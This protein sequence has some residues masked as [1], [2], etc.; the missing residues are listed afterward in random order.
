MLLQILLLSA[1]AM[2]PRTIP[3]TCHSLLSMIQR[4]GVFKA[5]SSKAVITQE[6]GL[7]WEKRTIQTEQ[8]PLGACP[9]ILAKLVPTKSHERLPVVIFLHPTGSRKESMKPHLRTYAHKGF[10]AVSIDSRYH[11]E[12][13]SL[14]DYFNALVDAWRSSPKKPQEK[15]FIFD[16]TFDLIKVVDFLISRADVDRSRIGVTG[17]SLGGMHSWFLA[18]ADKRI[19]AAAPMI[20]VQNFGWAIEN[21][22]WQERAASIQPVFD[23]AAADLGT[24]GTALNKTV[25]RAVW[26]KINPGLIDQFDAEH[27]LRCIAPR[28]LLIANGAS[29][30]R[31]PMQGVWLA[32]QA[33][34]AEWAKHGVSDLLQ[35]YLQ[36]NGGHETPSEMLRQVE[37]FFELHLLGAKDKEEHYNASSAKLKQRHSEL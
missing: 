10:L 35:V 6:G 29:D 25:V 37:S 33:V 7:V 20:G 36:K 8:G 32:V 23:A 3:E 12:R 34:K 9:T 27:T 2:A 17:I 5:H 11:G 15:P 28:P 19:A 24:E 18:A 31:C 4:P 21:D 16:S 30:G 1:L 22:Q 13:G 14:S 26:N